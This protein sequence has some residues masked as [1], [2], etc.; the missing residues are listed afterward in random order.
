M[1]RKPNWVFSTAEQDKYLNGPF[2]IISSLSY[3]NEHE[4]EIVG[5]LDDCTPHWQR[6]GMVIRF[7]D[8]THQTLFKLRWD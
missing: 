5:W 8:R 1:V 4:R 2:V 7:S 3:F 6:Q